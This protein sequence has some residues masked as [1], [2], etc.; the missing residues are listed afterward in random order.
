MKSNKWNIVLALLLMTSITVQAQI[1]D[2]TNFGKI[3]IVDATINTVTEGTI[4]NCVI[5]LVK[6]LNML[7]TTAQK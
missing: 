5:T 7:E 1:T 6:K 2:K 4:Q 3:A